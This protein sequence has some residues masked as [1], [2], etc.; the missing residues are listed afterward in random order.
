[1]ASR[2]RRR[3]G[4][5]EEEFE[6]RKRNDPDS[7]MND[8][9]Q[10]SEGTGLMRLEEL[11]PGAEFE[12]LRTSVLSS[13]SWSPR[14]SQSHKR[15]RV[16]TRPTADG[17]HDILAMGA[18]V[19]RDPGLT[20]DYID[21]IQD[22]LPGQTK[23][24]TD[25]IQQNWNIY[26]NEG[27]LN[28]A[29]NKMAATLS[30]GGTYKVRFARKGKQRGG[31]SSATPE[32]TLQAVLDEFC[33]SVNNAPLDGTVTGSRGLQAIIHQ[34]VRQTLVEGDWMG[35]TVWTDHEVPNFSSY[36][37][38]MTIQ[39]ISMAN[40]QSIPELEGTGIEAYYWVPPQVLIQQITSPKTKDIKL[41]V[42]KF[43]PSDILNVLKRDKKVLLDPALLLHVKHRGVDS[44]PFGESFIKA[45][46][47]GIAFKR[48]VEALD[49][50][51]MQ[52]LIN[53]LTIVMV[54]S[55]DPKSPYSKPDVAAARQ[56]LMKSFFDNPGPNM[57]V[58]WAGDDVKIEDV[59]AHAQMLQLDNRHT[60]ADGKIK[61]AIGVPEALLSGSTGDNKAA[62]WAAMIGAAAQ[63][64]ELKNALEQVF[65]SLGERIAIENG[66]DQFDI[67]FEFDNSLMTDRAEEWNQLRNDLLC[68]AISYRTFLNARNIDPDAEFRIKAKEMGQDPDN[69]GT[70]WKD[71][72]MPPQG[73]AGQA[74]GGGPPGTGPGKVPGSGQPA[75][76]P[77]GTTTPAPTENKT[78]VSKR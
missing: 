1:M 67:K 36:S 20:Q 14:G 68:G 69:T 16:V 24:K 29:V 54:G 65:T 58:V 66:F 40:V 73:L 9:R 62:G 74:A 37:L 15:L 26:L 22:F 39:S 51:C 3:K 71:V 46:L 6:Q 41:L 64:E 13:G 21:S 8:A 35:R 42:K 44:R 4:E 11:F 48:A 32:Q 50:V 17:G 56:A 7:V 45:A 77:S 72:F 52:N 55:S 31:K 63:L 59:G 61:M 25:E 18:E 78:P 2:P 12:D 49:I 43:I 27:I 75:G 34:A 5:S 57:T 47:G 53:R 76:N 28:N 38:P 70:L 23:T 19:S 10:A 33:N 30:G 60:I